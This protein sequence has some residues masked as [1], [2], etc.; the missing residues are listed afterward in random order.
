MRHLRIPHLHPLV[1]FTTIR[2]FSPGREPCREPASRGRG[3]GC[4]QP[5]GDALDRHVEHVAAA[6]FEHGRVW[7]LDVVH[8]KD[9]KHR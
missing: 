1:P 5:S 6:E 3:D 8:G 4:H 2:S 7:I 9:S